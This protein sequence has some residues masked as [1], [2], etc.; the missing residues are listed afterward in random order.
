MIPP[1]ISKMRPS[2]H[3]P[4]RILMI[5]QSIKILLPFLYLKLIYPLWPRYKQNKDSSG[6]AG[7]DMCQYI[8]H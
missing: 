4:S 6:T 7:K 8:S 3:K 5:V 2:T 1:A